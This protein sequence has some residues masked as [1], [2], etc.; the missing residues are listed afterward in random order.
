[1]KGWIH[2][3]SQ[4]SHVKSVQDPQLPYLSL[5]QPHL[6]HSNCICLKPI[7]LCTHIIFISTVHYF[8]LLF[9]F[10]PF[11]FA[12]LRLC[13]STC[14][15]LSH[16]SECLGP[17]NSLCRIPPNAWVHVSLSV[18][19][20]RMPGSMYLSLSH[21]SECLGPCISLCHIPTNPWVHVSLSVA[22]FRMSGPCISVPS[23]RMTG[24]MCLCL[25]LA[26]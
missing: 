23:L 10:W 7:I 4:N 6:R 11:F 13:G 22:F 5:K 2:K 16:P 17:C 12:S 9:S 25:S 21:S 15:S 20:L 24:S 8:F 14:L 3:D 19:S 18:A 1:M 26:S